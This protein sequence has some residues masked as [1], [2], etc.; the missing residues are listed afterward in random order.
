MYVMEDEDKPEHV[1]SVLWLY[2][3]T[4]SN[5]TVR[6]S[7]KKIN[8]YPTLSFFPKAEVIAYVKLRSES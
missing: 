6:C 8:T 4:L 5:E 3:N 7:A 2:P 1:A